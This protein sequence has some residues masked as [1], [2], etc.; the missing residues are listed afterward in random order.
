MHLG[1]RPPAGSTAVH[2][3]LETLVADFLGT[4]AAITYGMGFATN[5]ASIPVLMSKGDLIISDALNHAS[6]VTGARASDAKVKVRC[7]QARHGRLRVRFRLCRARRGCCPGWICSSRSACHE[8]HCACKAKY[9]HPTDT[10]VA[11]FQAQ[12]R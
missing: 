3:E 2:Q 7:G 10:A 11:W 5:S 1:L 6:I 12:L 8:I 9:N 4:E